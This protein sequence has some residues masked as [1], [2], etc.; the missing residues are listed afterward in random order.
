MK[1]GSLLDKIAAW[2]IRLAPLVFVNQAVYPEVINHW[3][4]SWQKNGVP[5][6]NLKNIELQD[7]K[8]RI[9]DAR[10]YLDLA[11]SIVHQNALEGA[12]CRDYTKATLEIYK[13]LIEKAGKEDL[14]NCVESVYDSSHN[15]IVI[16]EGGEW[17]KYESMHKTPILSIENVREHSNSTES[18]RTFLNGNPDRKAHSVCYSN[19]NCHPTLDAY[20]QKG[21]NLAL[22]VKAFL[23]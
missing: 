13:R 4:E 8:D 2:G 19:S 6:A 1:K 16:R 12:V 18:S 9:L 15:W 21:G 23:N 10:N 5:K 22:L 20:F 14:I 17:V 3:A 7:L 11:N